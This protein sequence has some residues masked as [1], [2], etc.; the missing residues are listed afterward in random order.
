MIFQT[1]ILSC[2]CSVANDHSVALISLKEKRPLV[3]A[4]RHMFPVQS[5]K[6]RPIEDYMVISCTDSTAYIWQMETGKL[7]LKPHLI[8]TC[9]RIIKMFMF[10]VHLSVREILIIDFFLIRSVSTSRYVAAVCDLNPA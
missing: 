7:G 9:L 2:V 4:S 8:T 10:E 5:V 3:F 1:R 6:W